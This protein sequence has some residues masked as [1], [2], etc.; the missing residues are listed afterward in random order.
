VPWCDACAKFWNPPS[1]HDGH[2]PACGTVLEAATP[3]TPAATDAEDRP[4]APW[5]FTLLLIALIIYLSYRAY[6]GVYWLS[7]HV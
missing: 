1:L 3:P 4:H 2:C 7:H 6:Q 5:H